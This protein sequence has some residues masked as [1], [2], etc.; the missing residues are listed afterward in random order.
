MW[1]D[2]E[3][4]VDHGLVSSRRPAD[5]PAFNQRVIEEFAGGGRAASRRQ[6]DRHA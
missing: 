1:V 3:A 4:C 6:A 5:I 2:R